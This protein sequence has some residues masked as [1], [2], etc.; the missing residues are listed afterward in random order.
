MIITVI[1]IDDKN[2]CDVFKFNS[3]RNSFSIV[4]RYRNTNNTNNKE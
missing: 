4:K 3:Q 2:E 1:M